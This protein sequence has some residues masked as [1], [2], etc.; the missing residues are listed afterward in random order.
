MLVSIVVPVYKVE[1]YL[2]Q[3]LDSIL[4]QTFRDFEVIVVDD[5]SPDGCPAIVDEYAAKDSRVVALHQPNGGYGKAVNAGIARARGKYVGIVE[6]DD[7]IEPDMYARLVE[8]AE[9]TGAD[10]TRCT[11]FVFD[12]KRDTLWRE[13]E[14]LNRRDGE[15]INP[16]EELDIFLYHS[17]PWC[18]LYRRE[19]FRTVRLSESK[20]ASYQDLTFV[21]EALLLSGSM[22]IVGRPMLHYRMEN[23]Q[24][25]SSTGGGRNLM[26]IVDRCA[27][28]WSFMR[29]HGFTDPRMTAMFVNKAVRAVNWFYERIDAAFRREFFDRLKDFFAPFAAGNG[30]VAWD[31]VPLE[32]RVWLWTVLAGRYDLSHPVLL[33]QPDAGRRAEEITREVM[34]SIGTD[35]SGWTARLF[36]A[37]SPVFPDAKKAILC[38]V[39]EKYLPYLSVCIASILHHASGGRKYDIV[40][41]IDFDLDFADRTKFDSMLEGRPNVSIRFFDIRRHFTMPYFRSLFVD[42]HLSLATYYRFAA[43]YVLWNY[44]RCLWLDCDTVACED[45]A[46]LLDADIGDCCVGGCRD[47]AVTAD[48]FVLFRNA[49]AYLKT[50]GF[51]HEKDYICAGVMLFNLEKFRKDGIVTKLLKTCAAHR[52]RMHD[53]DGINLVCQDSIYLLDGKWNFIAQDNPSI[54][55]KRMRPAIDAGIVRRDGVWHFAGGEKP[56]YHPWRE[57]SFVWWRSARLSPYYEEL[58]MD[59]S[60]MAAGVP[61]RRGLAAQRARARVI[62]AGGP[63]PGER[64]IKYFLPYGFMCRYVKNHYGIEVDKPLFCSKNP[65]VILWRLFKFSL[66][67]GLVIR[68]AYRFS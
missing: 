12:G 36:G 53:Q 26:A 65:F 1:K 49:L 41:F 45:V 25:S 17:A 14:E 3:C 48:I 18:Y 13:V 54:Y 4:S 35:L 9:R 43:P 56:W 31:E 10:L 60:L 61:R 51:R 62:Q 47:L 46:A 63:D 64:K 16:H 59:L 6:S 23:G 19:L 55:P 37:L 58:L 24:G 21:G 39:D 27:E 11:F 34:A 44:A 5:G 67:Y 52:F 50:L 15:T 40:V 2:R 38:A 30:D 68:I 22:A 28:L 29:E 33:Q 42:R 8:A 66:P 32:V 20:G 57:C 7:W